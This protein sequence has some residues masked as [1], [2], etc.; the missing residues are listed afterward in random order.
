MNSVTLSTTKSY[1]SKSFSLKCKCLNA[2]PKS[3]SHTHR[4]QVGNVQYVGVLFVIPVIVDIHGHRF[5]IY[6][7]V[8]EIHEN[9]DLVLG[10]KNVFELE[11]VTESHNSCFSFLNRSIPFFPKEKTEIPPTTQKMVIVEAPFQEELSGMAIIKILDM[12]KHITSLIKLKFI[13]NKATLKITNNTNDMV[14]FDTKDMIGI[15]NI[16]SL[17]YYKV[18]QDVLQKHMGKHYHFEFA[19]DVCAQLN[20]FVNL[21]KKEEENPKEEYP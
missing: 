15:L 12:T 3:T 17:G 19:E 13:R 2:L 4:I 5:E 1:M 8:S 18:K 14:T 10:I 6:T 21:L 7:L 11:G 9:V 20:R 16:R